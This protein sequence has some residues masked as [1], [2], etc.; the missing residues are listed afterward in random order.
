MKYNYNSCYTSWHETDLLLRQYDDKAFIEQIFYPWEELQYTDFTL[1]FIF[2]AD[3]WWKWS[4][5]SRC[6]S[7]CII[8]KGGI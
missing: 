6:P 4:N 1:L 2:Y 3:L 5:L 8:L 7:M